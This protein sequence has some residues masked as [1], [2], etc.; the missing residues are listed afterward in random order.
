MA[1]YIVK[2]GDTLRPLRA[3]LLEGDQP[4]DLTGAAVEMRLR[5]KG[6][7]LA[8]PMSVVNLEFRGQRVTGVE[9]RWQPEDFASL[10]E[11]VAYDLEFWVSRDGQ[12]GKCP[13]E[14]HDTLDVQGDVA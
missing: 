7:T 13:T 14:G 10:Q 11:G 8:R 9:Y 2:H 12:L 3:V 6:A 5:R 4:L 1:R